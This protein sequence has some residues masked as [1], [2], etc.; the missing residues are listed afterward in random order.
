VTGKRNITMM[1]V[2]DIMLGRKVARQ[3]KGKEQE[4]IFSEVKHILK[5][6]DLVIGNLETPIIDTRE[7]PAHSARVP[8]KASEEVVKELKYAKFGIMNVANNHILD[9]GE[10]GLINTLEVLKSHQIHYVGAG[11]NINEARCPLRIRVKDLIITFLSYCS[12]YNATINKAGTAPLDIKKIREDIADTKKDSDIIIV[13]LH[14]GVEYADYPTP[15]FIRLA[16]QV[17]D[18]GAQVALGHHPHVLQGI[19]EYHGGV[20]AYSLGNF[21]FDLADENIRQA[22]YKRCLLTEKYGVRFAVDDNR[23]SQSMILEIELND[24]G[25]LNYKVHP[26]LIGEDFRPVPL[27]GKESEKLTERVQEL[28]K[29]IGNETLVINQVLERVE[30]DSLLSYLNDRGI[31]YYIRNLGKLRP[32]HFV[33]MLDILR[34]KLQ[35]IKPA[36]RKKG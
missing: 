22:A 29:N 9:Y 19:E 11:R 27:E 25:F 31:A 26:V 24:E 36:W 30:T 20:I 35:T 32:S 4:W 6:A 34:A 2:G 14:H 3:A 17:I 15:G 16:R 5:Q 10:K 23:P 28:G 13:S 21:V 18:S 33:M 12:S 7:K 1:A 8:L